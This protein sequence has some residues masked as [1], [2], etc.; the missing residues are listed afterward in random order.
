MCVDMGGG[1]TVSEKGVHRGFTKRGV[2]RGVHEKGVHSVVHKKG[3]HVN[4]VNPPG[5]GPEHAVYRGPSVRPDSL[6]PRRKSRF[7]F[8]A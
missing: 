2:H 8:H 1:F 6:S 5:H 3:V 4:P 7:F